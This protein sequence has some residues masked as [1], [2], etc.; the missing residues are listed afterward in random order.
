M[1]ITVRL[2]VS[3]LKDGKRVHV[4]AD[5]VDASE[6]EDQLE[7]TDGDEITIIR[8]NELIKVSLSHKLE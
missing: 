7:I 1:Q 8:A 3:Y 6:T 2:S 5:R 4:Q